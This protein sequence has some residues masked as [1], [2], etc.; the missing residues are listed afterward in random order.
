MLPLILSIYFSIN[1]T[2][3]NPDTVVVVTVVAK[4]D[5]VDRVDTA[6]ARVDTVVVR[7]VTVVVDTVASRVGEGCLFGNEFYTDGKVARYRRW[8]RW[9]IPAARCRW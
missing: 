5:T 2:V 1:Q 6:V 8:I 3:V 7:E 4:E 9:W